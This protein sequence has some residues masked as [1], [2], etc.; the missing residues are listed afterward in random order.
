VRITGHIIEATDDGEKVKVRMQ[1]ENAGSAQ[2]RDLLVVT[3]ELP[4]S[5]EVRR[6]YYLGRRLEIVLRPR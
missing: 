4:A 2:W 3:F 6:A 5:H 1:G